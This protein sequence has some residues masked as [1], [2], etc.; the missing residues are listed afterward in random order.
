M[1]MILHKSFSG[2]WSYTS[3]DA[4]E[5]SK[6]SLGEK[7]V[8]WWYKVNLQ[9][10]VVYTTLLSMVCEVFYICEKNRFWARA[11]FPKQIFTKTKFVIT[12]SIYHCLT[13]SSWFCKI[14]WKNLFLGLNHRIVKSR[15]HSQSCLPIQILS[16]RRYSSCTTWTMNLRFTTKYNWQTLLIRQPFSSQIILRWNCHARIL[17]RKSFFS[18][19]NCSITQKKAA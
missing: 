8:L 13:V 5:S 4:S 17:K 15:A 19:K 1:S 11:C 16:S 14:P 2:I 7:R 18:H 9:G 10:E 6:P 12:H 3:N